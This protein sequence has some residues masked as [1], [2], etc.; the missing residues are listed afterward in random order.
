MA[1]ASP[2]AV[3]FRGGVARHVQPLLEALGFAAASLENVRPGTLVAYWTRALPH[4][5]R[6]DVTLWC[7]GGTANGLRIRLDVEGD[8]AGGVRPGE[9]ELSIPWPDPARPRAV[10]LS[11]AVRELAPHESL[12][13]LEVALE[14]LAGALVVNAPAIAE[15]VPVLAAALR[16][17][18]AE[19]TWQSAIERSALLWQQR[20]VRGELD[21][22]PVLAR[23]VFMGANLLSVEADGKRLTFRF[24]TR[25][26]DRETAIFV[27][28]WYRTPAGTCVASSLTDG[29]TTWRF[30]PRGALIAR[31]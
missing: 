7:E 11:L 15:R 29:T 23:V 2:V 1:K 30:D 28:D 18:Q 10:G 17:L 9:I 24:D 21:A 16:S 22:R 6:L 3:A 13:R 14:F 12:E 8:V 27:S 31:E 25:A 26:F 4:A 5:Q 19:P 20:H